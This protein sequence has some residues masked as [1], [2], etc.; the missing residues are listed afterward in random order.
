MNPL[1]YACA[2]VLV[3]SNRQRLGEA[4][5]VCTNQGGA[6]AVLPLAL[7]YTCVGTRSR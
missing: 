1:G 2:F 3:P 6:F 7:G 4:R 5:Q